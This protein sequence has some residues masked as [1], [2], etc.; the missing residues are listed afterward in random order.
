MA[1]QLAMTE[2]YQQTI[3]NV[4]FEHLLNTSPFDPTRGHWAQGRKNL[5][6]LCDWPHPEHV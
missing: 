1:W 3:W 4:S 6:P 5:P 2:S